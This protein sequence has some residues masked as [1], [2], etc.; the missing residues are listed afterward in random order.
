MTNPVHSHTAEDRGAT[1][2]HTQTADPAPLRFDCRLPRLLIH[3]VQ[4]YVEVRVQRVE[5][6]PKDEIKEV[7]I[8]LITAAAKDGSAQRSITFDEGS[9]SVV[10]LFFEP[11][12]VGRFLADLQITVTSARGNMRADG[13]WSPEL[14]IEPYPDSVKS[15]S[16]NMS[17]GVF[18]PFAEQMQFMKDADINTVVSR[19][20]PEAPWEALKLKWSWA[21]PSAHAKPD[22]RAAFALLPAFR[23]VMLTVWA[24]LIASGCWLAANALLPRNEASLQAKSAGRSASSEAAVLPEA[25]SLEDAQIGQTYTVRLPGGTEMKLCYCP[26]TSYR[27]E[28]FLMGSPESEDWH[29]KTE[30]Q[31]EV[32]LTHGFW[33]AQTECT[34]AQWSAITDSLH[35]VQIADVTRK[36]QVSEVSWTSFTKSYDQKTDGKFA[37]GSKRETILKAID[38]AFQTL[39][40]RDPVWVH[41]QRYLD[42][43][44]LSY[45]EIGFSEI[46]N[47]IR[48]AIDEVTRNESTLDFKKRAANAS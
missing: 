35:D 4:T 45:S 21:S 30:Q 6:V 38:Q 2:L 32:R 9:S 20:F 41:C 17:G 28:P 46:Q 8:T 27:T 10:R 39:R 43:S 29:D 1:L 14:Q 3:G 44:S 15:L 12:R 34:Q 36:K 13:E 7:N 19:E 18:A 24:A 33:M 23:L 42:L 47:K 26:P 37:P 31:I 40:P 22:L 48:K 16:I 5:R 11:S 25:K